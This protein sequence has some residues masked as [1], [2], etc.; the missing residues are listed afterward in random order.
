[1]PLEGGERAGNA[2]R[3]FSLEWILAWLNS[4]N[5]TQSTITYNVISEVWNYHEV[6]SC[7]SI[8]KLIAIIASWRA[9]EIWVIGYCLI[10]SFA[11]N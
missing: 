11:Y 8:A 9:K 5:E 6:H 10:V 1:M 3:I 7:I 2:P 4:E